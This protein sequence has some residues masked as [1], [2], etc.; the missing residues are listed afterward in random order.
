[1]PGLSIPQLHTLI[2]LYRHKDVTLSQVAGRIGLKLPSTS[3]LVDSLV[4]RK[5]VIR[6]ASTDDRRYIRLKLSS[7]GLAELVRARRSTG[8]IMAKKMAVLTPEQQDRIVTVLQ[9]LRP[10]FTTG[11]EEQSPQTEK[12]PNISESMKI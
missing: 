1:M 5:L 11:S 3:K 9:D 12:N 8:A 7:S 4:E 10:L 6:R 2:F